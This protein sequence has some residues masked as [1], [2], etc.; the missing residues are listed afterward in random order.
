MASQFGIWDTL[1][2]FQE[3]VFNGRSAMQPP[4]EH[5]FKGCD[6]LLDGRLTEGAYLEALAVSIG[7]FTAAP[8]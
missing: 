3:G 1:G 7:E 8:T 5:R 6:D 4:P 2:A